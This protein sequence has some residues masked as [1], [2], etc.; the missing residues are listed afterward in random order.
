MKIK[1]FLLTLLMICIST[2]AL[3]AGQI[4]EAEVMEAQKEWGNAIVKIGKA[5]ENKSDYKKIALNAVKNLYAY[6]Q[7]TVLFKPTKAADKQF[8]PTLEEAVSYFVTGVAPEDK[9]FALQPWSKVRFDDRLTVINGC[10]AISQGNYFFTDAKTGKVA[11]VEFTFGY[12][13]DDQGKLRI[14]L[15]HSSLP[16]IKK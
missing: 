11:K 6:D 15:H 9:G 13:K 14:F 5:Y 1:S 4:T 3:S 16:Y 2:P 7:G 10:D 12:I 8:R